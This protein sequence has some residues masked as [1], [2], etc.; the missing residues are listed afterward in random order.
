M[1][2]IARFNR[3]DELLAN[4]ELYVPEDVAEAVKLMLTRPPH[5]TVC[6]LVLLP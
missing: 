3:I 5:V 2:V 1:D 6:D 4:A